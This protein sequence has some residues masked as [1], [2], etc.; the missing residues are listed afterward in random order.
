MDK[1]KEFLEKLNSPEAQALLEGKE[2][3]ADAEEAL[4]TYAEIAKELGFDVSEKDMAD[5]LSQADAGQKGRT[6]AAAGKICELA[7][8]DLEN[9]A[10]GGSSGGG[11]HCK[12]TFIDEENC[13]TND[14]CDYTWHYYATYHCKKEYRG[15]EPGRCP[16]G[17]N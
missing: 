8:E 9:V 16:M 1:I 2:K 10:G 14:G 13:W 17:I 4:R 15:K 7:D 6:E 5:Y 11:S 3:P 12:D